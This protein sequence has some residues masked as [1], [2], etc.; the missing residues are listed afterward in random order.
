[1]VL[2]GLCAFEAVAAVQESRAEGR[3]K[4][5]QKSEYTHL[6]KLDYAADEK[7]VLTCVF[8]TSD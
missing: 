3:G 6:N 7:L 1:M 2:L 5:K 8:C 4:K